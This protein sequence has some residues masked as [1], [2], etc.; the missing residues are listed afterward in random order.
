MTFET[1]EIPEFHTE[2]NIVTKRMYLRGLEYVKLQDAHLLENG[3]VQPNQRKAYSIYTKVEEKYN[4]EKNE[5][6]QMKR[7]LKESKNW[8]YRKG[9]YQ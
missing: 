1:T 6:E 5:F 8:R 2:I 3:V 9:Q 7:K 4:P